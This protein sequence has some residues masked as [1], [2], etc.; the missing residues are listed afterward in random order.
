MTCLWFTALHFL[1][2]SIPGETPPPPP[3]T[4]FG[5][6]EMIEEIVG[7]AIA[8]TPIA[9]IGVGGIGKTSIA[10][11]VLHDDRI[12]Q[13]FGENRRFI[14][15]DQF[16][17][18]L[19]HLL[20]RLSKV[21]GAGIEHPEYL[22]TLLPFLSSKE[23]LIVLDNAESILDPQGT[24]SQEIYNTMEELCRLKTVCLCITSRI[25]TVPP[26]CETVD[27]PPLSMESTRDAFRR[28]YKC[29]KWTDAVDNILQQLDGH[30]LSTTLLA[31]VAR[32][33]G[34]SPERLVKEW[35][36]R[37]TGTLQ[38]EYRL[39]LATTIELSLRSPM[40]KW[41]GP[42]ARDLLGVIAFYPQGVDEDNV[43]WLFPTISNTTLI[44]DG[45]CNLS[46]T[47]RNDGF[48]TMLA[49]LRDY[50]RPEDPTSSPLFCITKISYFTRLSLSAPTNPNHPEFRD[51]RWI[52]LED[53]NVEHLLNIL[54]SIDTDSD[55]VWKACCDFMRHLYWHKKRQTVLGPKIEGLPDDHPSKP[56]CLF[57]LARF[58]ES[59][60]NHTEQKRLLNHTLRLRRE[61]GDEAG[62]AR[63]LKELSDVNRIL[64]QYEEGIRQA[65]EVVKISERLGDTD[66]QSNAW[67]SLTLLLFEDKQLDAEEAAALRTIDLAPETGQEFLIC[68]SHRV[69]GRIYRSKGEK[70]KAIHHFET[71]L[72]IASP[73]WHDQLFWIHHSLALLFL[74]KGVPSDANTHIERAKSH[75]MDGEYEMGR[76][77]KLQA[78][79]WLLQC[80]FEDAKSEV[81]CAI[82]TLEKLG[83]EMGVEDC[84]ITLLS[85]EQAMESGGVDTGEQCYALHSLTLPSYC[86]VHQASPPCMVQA[87]DLVA[88]P[89]FHS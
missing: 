51:G 72:E 36:E 39:R 22:T 56:D 9:L 78:A 80:R 79:F 35:E 50:L 60:G 43:D 48:I 24:D 12:K 49:P 54:T 75:T 85:I 66:L 8:L 19:S 7:F 20:S 32:Q 18:T 74:N 6:G 81:L 77:M 63:A 42:E 59:I 16:P 30:P 29:R 67:H 5:R 61:R 86:V 71:A 46:L 84:R 27:V 11:T 69:L 65:E 44:F 88:G 1:G 83:D 37:Q 47:Y 41:L 34:W 3:R 38:T 17:A 52:T 31:T 73:D 25:S 76:A 40:F 26:L 82:D 2:S 4:C 68:G 62:L 64:G 58:F 70:E 87:I 23:M 28:I 53:T 15:C 13:R 89:I 55:D 57:W 21:T 33:N 45:F 10:L 14:R